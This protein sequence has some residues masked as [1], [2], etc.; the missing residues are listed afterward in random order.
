MPPARSAGRGSTAY[1]VVGGTKGGAS[2]SA[3][4]QYP[5][6]VSGHREGVRHLEERSV[7]K[8]RADLLAPL[9]HCQ[10]RLSGD[11]V[12][13]LTDPWMTGRYSARTRWI[14]SANEEALGV[15]LWRR[16]RK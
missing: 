5:P 13:P 16:A 1:R 3:C 4:S 12:F 14:T 6:S 7:H 15:A 11:Q 9:G 2:G 10:L 8:A